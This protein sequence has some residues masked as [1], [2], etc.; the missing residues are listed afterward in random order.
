MTRNRLALVAFVSALSMVAFSCGGSSDD[1]RDSGD[2]GAVTTAAPSTSENLTLEKLPGTGLQPFD[3]PPGYN[4]APESTG[5]RTSV[6]DC[7]KELGRTSDSVKAQ[8]QSLG[9][10]GCDLSTFQSG[11][12]ARSSV[13]FLFRDV[14]GAA[15]GLPV[16]RAV[17]VDTTLEGDLKVEERRDIPVS[18]LGDQSLPGF[19]FTASKEG[20]KASFTIYSWRSRN[21]AFFLVGIDQAQPKES[22]FLDL[23][24]KVAGRA[25]A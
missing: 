17:G 8:L 7:V 25:G 20:K 1:E 4:P 16:L 19:T 5:R 3:L 11:S 2:S 13:A 15:Q 12:S 24:K 18:G 22:T 10:E 6:A 9:L 14:N 23:S 21:V